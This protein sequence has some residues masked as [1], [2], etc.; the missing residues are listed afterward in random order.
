MPRIA[1]ISGATAIGPSLGPAK[2]PG[3]S[4]RI[5]DDLKKTVLFFGLEDNTPG[6]GGINCVGTGF[7][8]GYDGGNGAYLVTA[9]HLA[10]GLGGNPFLVRVNTKDGGSE[11]IPVDNIRWYEHPDPNVDVAVLPLH[12]GMNSNYDALYLP[13][14]MLASDGLVYHETIKT[15]GVGDLTF[16]IGL[17]RLMSGERRNLPIVH[18]G[19]IAM[20]PRDELIPVR[21]WRPP[22]KRIFVE[23]YLVETNALE[24]LS[25]SPVFMR[26][27]ASFS[28]L[29]AN[30]VPDPRILPPMTRALAAREDIKLLGLW[31]AS[32][33]APPDEVMVGRGVRVPVG[34]GIVVPAQKIID[35]L[36][37]EEL[38]EMRNDS[39]ARREAEAP[40]ATPDAAIPMTG[41][42]SALETGLDENPA[43]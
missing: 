30:I 10:H 20:M 8:L 31:Q 3:F 17:F 34:M 35:T 12:L 39:K 21:D 23:G 27:T 4:M 41:G 25:G 28:W 13:Q 18:S 16:T 5:D 19:S 15:V 9:K 11:N 2:S 40:A 14:L 26:P 36:E 37:Q 22:G 29:P 7:L 42:S 33:D 6:K 38:V 32:W 24:G 1:G 43:H